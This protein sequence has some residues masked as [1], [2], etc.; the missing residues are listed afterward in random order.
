MQNL[1]RLTL[2]PLL[3]VAASSAVW[4]AED[5]TPMVPPAEYKQAD[6]NFYAAGDVLKAHP[7]ALIISEGKKTQP[8]GTATSVLVLWHRPGKN[9]APDFSEAG[10]RKDDSYFVTTP[11]KTAPKEIY[12]ESTRDWIEPITPPDM[13]ASLGVAP[14][15]MQVREPQGDVQVALPSAPASFAPATEGETIP[16]GTVLKTGA[17]GTA[18]VLFGGVDS[19]RLMPNSAAAVQQTVTAQSRTAE[20]DLTAGGVFSK[21]GTQVGVKG[22]YE[23]HTPFGNAVAHGGDFV[24]ITTTNHVDV[25]IAQGTVSLE[26]PDTKKVLSSTSDG[27]GPL[28]LVRFPAISD[29][30]QSIQADVETLTLAMN[31]VPLANQKVKALRDKKTAGTALSDNEQA[32]LKRIKGVPCLT[33]LALVEPPAPPPAPP[34]AVAPALAGA[35]APVAAPEATAPTPV[36]TKPMNVVV[37]TDGSVR[38]RHAVIDLPTFQT[39]LADAAKKN[40]DQVFIV[41]AGSN[42][43]QDKVQGVMD[44]F[45]AAH[46]EHVTLT[47]HPL[48]TAPTPAVAATPATPAAT[49]AP[50]PHLAVSTAPMAPS[51]ATTPAVPKTTITKLK[52]LPLELRPDGN[53]DFQNATLTLDELK[54]KLEGI[55]EATPTQSISIRGKD[56]VPE[57]QLDKVV[58]LCKDAK[59]KVRVAWHHTSAPHPAAATP[60]IPATS[61]SSSP[62]LPTPGLIMHPSME[63]APT[64]PPAS[65]PTPGP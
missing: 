37:R 40:P 35:P 58:A 8:D 29:P 9:P 48:G 51:D 45:L 52:P 11:G 3:A 27:S 59:L 53:V 57:G 7:N 20:V 13:P 1:V 49:D 15:A 56:N 10:Y 46:L 6:S 60:A 63:P 17:N 31:F 36:Q 61:E 25:W 41:T 38:F 22:Q 18:A 26:E 34:V 55:A 16:N 62:N 32:Y 5:G 39:K 64:P 23:V 54:P 33:K 12:F 28:R 19:A 47:I 65:T 4:A 21:V 14:D 44:S 50:A 2:L 42:V 43:P 24:T 30:E